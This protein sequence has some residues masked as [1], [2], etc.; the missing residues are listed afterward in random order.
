MQESKKT[1]KKGDLVKICTNKCNI[2]LMEMFGHCEFNPDEITADEYTALI[3]AVIGN[4]QCYSVTL[5]TGYGECYHVID[6]EEII[7]PASIDELPEDKR[8]KAIWKNPIDEIKFE[9]ELYSDN[10]LK[11]NTRRISLAVAAVSNLHPEGTI[12]VV[13]MSPSQSFL[14]EAIY[15]DMDN[16]LAKSNNL[17]DERRVEL[18]KSKKNLL[19]WFDTLRFE[20][21]YEYHIGV[22]EL[23]CKAYEKPATISYYI[24]A[25]NSAGTKAFV[26]KDRNDQSLFFDYLGPDFKN[27]FLE[28]S[29]FKSE[30][31]KSNDMP[32]RRK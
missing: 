18:E 20:E 12:R 26:M 1:Y 8:D 13:E 4:G 5:F 10:G 9:S 2:H 25:V 22:D 6:N 31:I 27:I 17:S 11:P 19:K 7:G 14:R 30:C 3:T 32:R 23:N 16:T 15:K 29:H 28:A 21:H 24:V